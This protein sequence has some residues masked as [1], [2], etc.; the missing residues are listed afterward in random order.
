MITVVMRELSSSIPLHLGRTMLRWPHRTAA[1][2]GA[3]PRW[4]GRR[5]RQR[6]NLALLFRTGNRAEGPD[7]I[8]WS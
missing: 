5:A 6:L 8:D 4:T 2:A 1:A 7:N 3:I